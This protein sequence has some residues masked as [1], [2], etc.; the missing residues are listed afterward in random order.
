MDRGTDSD[1][2]PESKVWGIGQ[3]WT[4]ASAGKILDTSYV[5]LHAKSLGHQPSQ[6]G[7]V[8]A[9]TQD[10]P[11]RAKS[12]LKKRGHCYSHP[13]HLMKRQEVLRGCLQALIPKT[14]IILLS[15]DT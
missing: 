5:M 11:Q 6:E 3:V 7:N 4:A 14:K 10:S 2:S 9:V 13:N 15:W 8:I 12:I 1:L